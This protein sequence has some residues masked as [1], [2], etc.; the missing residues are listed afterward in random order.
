MFI[1]LDVLYVLGIIIIG[2][3]FG[4]IAKHDG[5]DGT[6]KYMF[7]VAT[8]FIAVPFTASFVKLDYNLISILSY[9]EGENN[10][11]LFGQFIEHSLMLLSISGISSYIGVS[12]LDN[13]ANTVLKSDLDKVKQGI[14]KENKKLNIDVDR[15]KVISILRSCDECVNNTVLYN[16]ELDKALDVISKYKDI[17]DPY[18]TSFFILE[19]AVYKRRKDYDCAI[20]ILDKLI[21]KYPDMIVAIYNKGCYLYLNNKKEE[22]KKLIL[23]SLELECNNND[24]QEKLRIKVITSSE[25]DIKDLFDTDEL[26]ALSIKYGVNRI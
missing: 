20:S 26:E 12:A 7:G 9:Y 5:S 19:A 8:A 3:V 10:K 1:L 11:E 14:E 16:K 18:C 13:I 6:P 23:K 4:S 2:G 21:K 24:F 15:L 17:D 22:A 25:E